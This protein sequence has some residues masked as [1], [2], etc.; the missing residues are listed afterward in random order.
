M[1]VNAANRG[2][3]D[4]TMALNAAPPQKISMVAAQAFLNKLVSDNILI[5]VFLKNSHKFNNQKIS[6]LLMLILI[7]SLL[8]LLWNLNPA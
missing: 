5:K 8:G 2:E 1:F 7:S 4:A 3:L 6:S